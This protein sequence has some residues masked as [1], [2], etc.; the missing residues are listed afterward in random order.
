[1]LEIGSFSIDDPVSLLPFACFCS[2]ESRFIH[3]GLHLFAQPALDPFAYLPSLILLDESSA[4][5][6]K[7]SV[8]A[9]ELSAR[10]FAP[11]LIFNVAT[12]EQTELQHDLVQFLMGVGHSMLPL[13]GV[14]PGQRAGDASILWQFE[15]PTKGSC[16]TL[17]VWQF[18]TSA[19]EK[20]TPETTCG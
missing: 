2:P 6:L 9:L 20:T 1:A 8:V 7:L 19:R 14:E 18:C 11:L 5:L 16:Q 15:D 12:H 13:M 17:R 10:C 4:P 3:V